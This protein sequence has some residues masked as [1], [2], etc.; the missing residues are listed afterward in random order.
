[1]R[2]IAA[3]SWPACSDRNP[4][5]TAYRSCIGRS[6]WNFITIVSGPIDSARAK[7]S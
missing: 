4:C 2:L 5:S 7:C 1:M 3:H 6:G